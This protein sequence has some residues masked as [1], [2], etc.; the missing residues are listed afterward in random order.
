MAGATSQA[1][2]HTGIE[3]QPLTDLI[4]P[5]SESNHRAKLFV[6]PAEAADLSLN[7]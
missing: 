6:I 1:E 3:H 5:N 2:S 7:A 4:R